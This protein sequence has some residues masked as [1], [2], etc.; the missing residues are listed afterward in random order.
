MST[1]QR[2][3]VSCKKLDINILELRTTPV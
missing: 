3:N 1:V 2:N